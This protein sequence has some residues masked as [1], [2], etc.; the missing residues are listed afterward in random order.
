MGSLVHNNNYM[1]FQAHP[2]RFGMMLA[3]D[4][5]I[6]GIEVF[7][8]HPAQKS[9]NH[10]AE[11]WKKQYP[12]FIGISGSDHHELA[13]HPDAGILTEEPITSNA[14]LLKVLRSG[15]FECIRDVDTMQSCRKQLLGDQA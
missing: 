15:A 10:M 9:H 7:N 13:Q 3:E 12:K 1:F 11:E 14:Q 4:Y 6:D 8:G 5:V 2:F